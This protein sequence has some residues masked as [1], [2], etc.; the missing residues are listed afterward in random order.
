MEL[1]QESS[2]AIPR[3]RIIDILTTAISKTVEVEV[4]TC[5]DCQDLDDLSQSGSELSLHTHINLLQGTIDREIDLKLIDNPAYGE[6]Q[7]WHIEQ[8]QQRQN[9]L[10]NNLANLQAMLGAI[11]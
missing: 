2:K 11:Q 3:Q 9:G 1:N 6:L 7:R 8:V 10:V 4:T 5:I